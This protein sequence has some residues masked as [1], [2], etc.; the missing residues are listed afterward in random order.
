[1]AMM[2]AFLAGDGSIEF[3]DERATSQSKKSTGNVFRRF[4]A[5]PQLPRSF[6]ASKKRAN[7]VWLRAQALKSSFV[8]AISY[9]PS[10]ISSSE[11][12][13]A[14]HRVCFLSCGRS[15]RLV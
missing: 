2:D 4:Y 10:A 7:S 11:V 1:M 3:P 6:L 9:K 12:L 8:R 14:A 5:Q 15:V 13:P